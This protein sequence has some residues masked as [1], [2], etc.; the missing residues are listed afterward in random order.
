M[1]I[2]VS[3][4]RGQILHADCRRCAQDPLHPCQYGPDVLE[5]MRYDPTDPDREPSSRA[6]T[7]TRLLGCAR[8]SVLQEGN[9]YYID[10]DNAYPLTR[11]NMVHALME[12]A[13][14]PGVLTTLREHRFKTTIET[15]YGTQM[16]S[17]KCDLV[18]VKS[19]EED[20]EGNPVSFHVNIVDYKTKSKIGHELIRAEDDHIAQINMYAWLVTK[21]LGK[22]LGYPE[23]PII[24]DTVEI[25]YF[26]MEKS[27]R[28]TSAGPLYAKGKRITGTKP[29]EYETLELAPIPLYSLDL[30]ELAI[31]KHIEERLQPTLA[32]ILP[33]EERW[34]CDR[35]PVRDLC[36]SLPA[37]GG[38]PIELL[39][40]NTPAAGG[41]TPATGSRT[42]RRSG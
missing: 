24:V 7:P 37:Q 15:S 29:W 14:Y 19:L 20:E 11:G 13:R 42:R 33:E 17:G 6:F 22:H 12:S 2:G 30:V 3:C 36:F 5:K 31:R 18:I 39:G 34:K 26:A 25:Q 9:D 41:M 23:L 27:R 32:P 40:P 16:F 35:C 21:T 28:F 4:V 10:I 38:T 1:Q 8:Q